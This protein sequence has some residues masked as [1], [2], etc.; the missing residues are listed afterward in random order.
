MSET[1]RHI[2]YIR[3]I[4]INEIRN[5]KIKQTTMTISSEFK[6]LC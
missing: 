2:A 1:F 3:I 5:M 6:T 4:I